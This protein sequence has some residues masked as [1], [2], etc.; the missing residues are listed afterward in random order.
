MDPEHIADAQTMYDEG[1]TFFAIGYQTK[2][3]FQVQY[4]EAQ[5]QKALGGVENN[6]VGHEKFRS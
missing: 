5:I 1:H 2:Q 6:P 3:W 4:T